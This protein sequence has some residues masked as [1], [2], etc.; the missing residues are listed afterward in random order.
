MCQSRRRLRAKSSVVMNSPMAKVKAFYCGFGKHRALRCIETLIHGWATDATICPTNYMMY[1]T[2]VRWYCWQS[3][4]NIAAQTDT[5]VMSG[6]IH[7]WVNILNINSEKNGSLVF[8][9]TKRDYLTIGCFAAFYIES[10]PFLVVPYVEGNRNNVNGV[11]L[12][13]LAW[14]VYSWSLW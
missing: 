10:F 14:Y 9:S 7:T 6:P 12:F 8:D 4:R 11:A 5:L 13:S 3:N 1:I 2:S